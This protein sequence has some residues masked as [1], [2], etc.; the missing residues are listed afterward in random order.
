MVRPTSRILEDE[1][2]EIICFNCSSDDVRVV[3]TQ[4]FSGCS[5]EVEVLEC[6]C[7]DCG[8]V[9]YRDEEAKK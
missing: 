5:S 6:Q 8:A 1:M 7:L 4:D 3:A 9:W 2:S